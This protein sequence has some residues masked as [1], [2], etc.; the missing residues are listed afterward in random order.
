VL[1]YWKQCE[2]AQGHS[3][4]QACGRRELSRLLSFVGQFEQA[5]V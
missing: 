1:T 2:G 4:V 3:L 5:L